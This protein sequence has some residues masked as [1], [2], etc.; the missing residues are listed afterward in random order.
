MQTQATF[1]KIQVIE[2]RHLLEMS[3][4]D[5][6]IV[7]QLRERIADYEKELAALESKDVTWQASPHA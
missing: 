5:P 2:L 1:L 3:G 4:D 7:P 6:I